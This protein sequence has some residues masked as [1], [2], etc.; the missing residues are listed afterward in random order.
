MYTRLSAITGL[1]GRVYPMVL[2]QNVEYPAVT[3]QR[4]TATRYYSFGRGPRMV[5]PTIQVDV[6]GRAA[7]G[8]Q[9]F[10]AV[11]G[12]VLSALNEIADTF[13]DA[14]RDDYEDDTELLRKSFDVRVWYRET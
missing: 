5:E 4:I 3:Y 6:Y 11:T 9:A 1:G 2:P 13:I 8:Q 12:T 7:L 14:E 10:D